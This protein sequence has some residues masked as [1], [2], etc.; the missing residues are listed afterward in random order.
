M[1]EGLR[2]GKFSHAYL[3]VNVIMY[4]YGY[5]SAKLYAFTNLFVLWQNKC[6]KKKTVRK[7]GAITVAGLDGS[8]GTRDR[9][10]AGK[11]LKSRSQVARSAPGGPTRV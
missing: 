2:L 6:K 3:L 7:Y 8:L 1:V 9:P 11:A 10:P 4:N 5:L